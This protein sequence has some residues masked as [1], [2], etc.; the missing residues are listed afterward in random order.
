MLG[1]GQAATVDVSRV[2][3]RPERAAMG[4][5]VQIGFTVSNPQATSQRVL[6]D[7]CVHYLRANGQ[8]KAKVFKLK[9]LSLAPGQTVPLAKRLSLAEMSTREHYPGLHRV[10]VLL[11][12]QPLPLGAFEG[13]AAGAPP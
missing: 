4:G 1:F 9:T 12:G 7:F 13:L 2:Q 3:I 8:A 10:D 5:A 11:N 6:V